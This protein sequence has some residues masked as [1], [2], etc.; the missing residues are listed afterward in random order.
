VPEAAVEM[1][2]LLLMLVGSV[3]AWHA[4][5]LSVG[6]SLGVKYPTLTGASSGREGPG[7][8]ENLSHVASGLMILLVW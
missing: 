7:V 8:G 2:D 6:V 4:S 1:P 3:L 5:G